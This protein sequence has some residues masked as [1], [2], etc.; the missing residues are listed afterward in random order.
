MFR[1]LVKRRYVLWPVCPLM[2]AKPRYRSQGTTLVL[3]GLFWNLDRESALLWFKSRRCDFVTLFHQRLR[4]MPRLNKPDGVRLPL[5][6]LDGH[7]ANN[8][9]DMGECT[10]RCSHSQEWIY[11]VC[12][13][14]SRGRG[15]TSPRF[16]GLSGMRGVLCRRTPCHRQPLC[17]GP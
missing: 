2:E 11:A 15:L 16:G 14:N 9:L 6:N 17:I 5:H 4:K 13:R 1:D 7:R 8:I 3:K 10:M 12:P